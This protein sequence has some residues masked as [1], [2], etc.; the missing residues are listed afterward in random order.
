VL[1]EPIAL[2]MTKDLHEKGDGRWECEF[3]PPG[4]AVPLGEPRVWYADESDDLLIVTHGNGVPMALRASLRLHREGLRPRVLDLRW[5]APLPHGEVARHAAE[6]G[7]VLVVDECRR[8]GG[9]GEAL[10]AEL[11]LRGLAGPTGA[12]PRVDL[13]T[14]WDTYIPLGDAAN[15]VLPSEED[16]VRAARR[17]AGVEANR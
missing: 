14:A 3:P 11:A 17:L 13:V 4:V 7:R 1:L 10:V 6:C 9:V 15:L 12:G 5:L 2:Y 16:I 8:S